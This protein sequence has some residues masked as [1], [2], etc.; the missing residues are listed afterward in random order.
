MVEKFQITHLSDLHLGVIPNM[1][2]LQHRSVTRWHIA[3]AFG[4]LGKH[5]DITAITG[6]YDANASRALLQELASK[7]LGSVSHAVDAFLITGDVCSVG[8]LEDLARAQRYLFRGENETSLQFPPDKLVVMPGN[9]DR[10]HQSFLSGSTNFEHAKAFEKVWSPRN[11]PVISA[12]PVRERR[13]HS[14]HGRGGLSIIC[15]D[16]A[17]NLA[18]SA[19]RLP[20]LTFF[21]DG[22]VSAETLS[23]LETMTTTAH[24]DGFSVVWGVHYPPAFPRHLRQQLFGYKKLLAAAQ[25]SG[26]RHI[27]SGH[28]H[29]Q[30]VYEAADNVWVHC[31]GTPTSMGSKTF[32]FLRH[33][34][35][36]MGGRVAF[37]DTE[38]WSRKRIRGSQKASDH[39]GFQQVGLV[40]VGLL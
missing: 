30:L 37:V 16:F 21:D 31:A 29:K 39:L 18:A 32:D 23:S 24:E 20:I 4:Q 36:I 28:T 27:F 15:A 14:K 11:Q 13:L 38:Q 6:T 3:D 22:S 8:R 25:R 2:G 19:R 26:V 7:E 1:R 40:Q 9:H 35:S 33:K 5:R 12:D 10:Y 17:L 34:I